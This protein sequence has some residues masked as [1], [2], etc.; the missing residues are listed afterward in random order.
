MADGTST[1][2][3]AATAEHQGFFAKLFHRQPKTV[4][5][6]SPIAPTMETPTVSP[7][8]APMTPEAVAPTTPAT[9]PLNA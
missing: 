5:P 8:T 4:S 7:T 2:E 6:A 9:T 3:G 1:P